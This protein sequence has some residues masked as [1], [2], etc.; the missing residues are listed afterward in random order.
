MNNNYHYIGNFHGERS[1]RIGSSDI[2][3]LF[4]N[5][6]KPTES[7]A[8]YNNTAITLFNEKTGITPKVYT[9]SLAAE[10]GHDHENKSLELF[11]RMFFG[12]KI[13][14]EF[15]FKKQAY[16]NALE[17]HRVEGTEKPNPDDYQVGLFRHNT[18]FIKDNMI[19]HPDCIYLGD[20]TLLDKPKNER[21]VTVEGITVDKAK[22]FYIEAKSARQEA[23]KRRDSLVKGYD[24]ESTT[25]Q[26][27]PLKHFV[28][29]QFQSPITNIETGYLALLHNTS[30]FQV[31]RVDKNKQWQNRIIDTVGKMLKHIELKKPPKEMAICLADIISLYPNQKDDFRNVS[32]EE[33]EKIVEIIKEYKKADKQEKNWKAVKKDC[34]DALSVYLKDYDTLM[35][36]SDVLVKWQTR[37][38][39]ERFGISI[40]DLKKN[41]PLRY[42]YLVKHDLIKKSADSKSVAIKYKP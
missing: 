28:Q 32:D 31:W 27:I 16:E 13:A 37:K 2:P 26:G 4:P 21:Y 8:G 39:S 40:K 25:W 12:Y 14:F 3:K 9:K 30:E 18:E 34:Q 15:K 22:P 36:G 6:E 38:G 7:L 11:I 1:T 41:E 33:Y 10:C 24:F 42:N 29:M 19:V 23:T 35:Y 17:W 5:P 20:T